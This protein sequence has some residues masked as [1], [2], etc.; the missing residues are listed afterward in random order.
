MDGWKEDTVQVNSV[1]LLNLRYLHFRRHKHTCHILWS[2]LDKCNMWG[3]EKQTHMCVPISLTSWWMTSSMQHSG[4]SSA[5]AEFDADRLSLCELVC[6]SA[7]CEQRNASWKRK[8]QRLKASGTVYRR[9]AVPSRECL[10]PPGC[11][12]C[13]RW[14]N[15][16]RSRQGKYF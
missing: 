9:L 10:L 2:A 15:W 8:K 12:R 7:C 16:R 5:T 3:L 13:A 11:C 6:R 1:L 14:C 4:L